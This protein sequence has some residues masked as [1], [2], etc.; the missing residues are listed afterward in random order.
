MPERSRADARRIRFVLDRAGL[1]RV[2]SLP[3]SGD[4]FASPYLNSLSRAAGHS[5]QSQERPAHHAGNFSHRGGRPAGSGGQA[6]VPKQ[7]FAALLAAALKPPAE[8]ADAAVYRRPETTPVRLFVSL[9][10]RPIVCPAT[11]QD[12][13]KDD[14]DPVLRAGQPGEQ[15]GFRGEHF[16]QRAAIRICRKTMPRWM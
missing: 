15:S 10:L 1:A 13:Q 14:G 7:T 8:F 3:L 16:R 5:A 12:P 9:L 11:E 2:M 4:T 6:G